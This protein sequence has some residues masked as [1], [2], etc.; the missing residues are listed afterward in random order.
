MKYENLI[1]VTKGS[2]GPALSVTLSSEIRSADI[3]IF[4]DRKLRNTKIVWAAYGIMSATMF[5]RKIKYF[6]FFYRYV[7]KHSDII[8]HKPTFNFKI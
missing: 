8:K 3:D 5:T 2:Q 4:D 1:E 7:F 6:N